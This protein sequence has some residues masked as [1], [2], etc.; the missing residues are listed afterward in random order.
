MLIPIILV[1]WTL[2][3]LNAFLLGILPLKKG[4]SA[5]ILQL[6]KIVSTDVTFVENESYFCNPYLQGETSSMEDKGVFLLDLPFSSSSY[7]SLFGETPKIVNVSL[8][9]EPKSLELETL[10][11]STRVDSSKPTTTKPLQV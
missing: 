9:P 3:L 8:E 5:L 11:E 7:S 6:E 2:E 1:S 4:I 10:R